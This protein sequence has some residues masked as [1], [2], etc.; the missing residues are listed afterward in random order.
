MITNSDAPI[1]D[2]LLSTDELRWA[3]VIASRDVPV[4]T[5]IAGMCGCNRMTNEITAVKEI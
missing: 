3:D 4:Y 5:Y 1:E 2:G